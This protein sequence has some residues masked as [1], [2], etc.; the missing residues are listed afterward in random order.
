MSRIR[1]LPDDRVAEFKRYLLMER[2]DGISG[3]EYCDI[4]RYVSDDELQS[5]IDEVVDLDGDAF[6]FPVVND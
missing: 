4:D 6:G 1:G 5:R 2:Q 3:E